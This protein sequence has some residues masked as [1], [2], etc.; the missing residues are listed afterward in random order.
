MYEMR[1]IRC[2]PGSACEIGVH[3]LAHAHRCEVLL[4]DL[5]LHPDGAQVGDFV[6]RLTSHDLLASEHVL[7]EDVAAGWR[8]KR[9]SLSNLAGPLDLGDLA[10]RRCPSRRDVA[11][12]TSTDRSRCCRHPRSA[13]DTSRSSRFASS[14]SSCAADE[15]R[16]VDR[17]QRLPA[18]DGCPVA[19]TIQLLDPAVDLRR[20][21]FDGRLVSGDLGDD[22]H[23]SAERT[24]RGGRVGDADASCFA[25]SQ[26]NG[27]AATA[28]GAVA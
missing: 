15:H 2:S 21:R 5:A 8:A 9:E 17:E 26:R 11:A 13:P 6:Q 23:L 19:F 25:G 27:V 16:R 24:K 7:L 1:P 14:S 28:L 3:R 10:L 22:A 12:L 20:D 4:E 18:R